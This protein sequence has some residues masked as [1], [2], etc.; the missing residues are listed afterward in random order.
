L[1][2]EIT[3]KYS[4]IDQKLSRA[5]YGAFLEAKNKDAAF[6]EKLIAGQLRDGIVFRKPGPEQMDFLAKAYAQRWEEGQ[7][8]NLPFN[9]L[10]RLDS[11]LWVLVHGSRADENSEGDGTTQ[12]PP[13][14][15]EYCLEAIKAFNAAAQRFTEA[16]VALTNCRA[17]RDGGG[18]SEFT[19]NDY[20]N[21]AQTLGNDLPPP[22]Q[23]MSCATEAAALELASEAM[24]AAAEQ[25]DFACNVGAGMGAKQ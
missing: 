16:L 10:A 4:K 17:R 11:D 2:L 5:T 6:L 24:N 20:D 19:Q 12:A 21:H 18:F 13:D 14:S 1:L 15:M 22:P 9:L 23:E 8:S 3:L 7:R 25:A